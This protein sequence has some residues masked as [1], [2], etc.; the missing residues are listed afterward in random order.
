MKLYLVL[1]TAF[2]E[3]E[4]DKVYCK[5]V[6]RLAPNKKWI[7]RWANGALYRFFQKNDGYFRHKVTFEKVPSEVVKAWN[8]YLD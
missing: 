4:D 2:K 6:L 7:K 8:I 3:K 5:Q 1:F